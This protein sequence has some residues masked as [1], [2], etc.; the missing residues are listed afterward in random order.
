MNFLSFYFLFVKALE[1]HH[2]FEEFVK[3][4]YCVPVTFRLKAEEKNI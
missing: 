1:S 2:H 3:R 4:L